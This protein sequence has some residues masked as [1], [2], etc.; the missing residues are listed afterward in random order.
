MECEG[1]GRQRNVIIPTQNC[2]K[3]A[4]PGWAELYLRVATKGVATQMGNHSQSKRG[5][6]REA[7]GRGKEKCYSG[8]T[9][10]G[11]QHYA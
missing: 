1:G 7:D 4:E 6:T 5:S 8:I 2:V 10:Y 9:K 3:R 11:V